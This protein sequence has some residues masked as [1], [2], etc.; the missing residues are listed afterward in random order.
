MRLESLCRIVFRGV[1]GQPGGG[2]DKRAYVGVGTGGNKLNTLLG[3]RHCMAV[4]GAGAG[5]GVAGRASRAHQS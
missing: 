5:A 3:L 4:R 1:P 2:V